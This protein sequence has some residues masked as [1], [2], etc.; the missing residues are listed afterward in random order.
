MAF[1]DLPCCE[2]VGA[3]A[4]K[5]PVPGGGGA[6]ALV[7]AVGAALGHMVGSLTVGKKRYSD[8][9]QEVEGLMERASALQGELLALA[10][11]DAEVFLPLAKAYKMPS[12]TQAEREAK[13]LEMEKTLGACCDVPLAIMEKC[14]EGARLC[15]AFA[16]KGAAI[17]AS[18]A[19]AGAAFCNA[20][21][22]AAALNVFI[23]TKAMSDRER[24][25][26]LNERARALL[27]RGGSAAQ[28]VFDGVAA[29]LGG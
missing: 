3:L 15:E 29:Q 20:A 8:V 4:S 28:A 24:A 10:E 25:A 19:G 26:E 21:L 17:A 16:G 2:F 14:C 23:N 12:G 6:A 27:A 13:A 9:E 11:R 7:G 1:M 18:D 22:Q 5:E